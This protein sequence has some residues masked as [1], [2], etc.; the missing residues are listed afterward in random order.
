MTRTQAWNKIRKLLG[1]KAAYRVGEKISGPEHR[2]KV[3]ARLKEIDAHRE[4]LNDEINRR[5]N[6]LPWYVEMVQ[7]KTD[8]YRERRKLEGWQYYYRFEA[9]LKLG[10]CNEIVAQGDTWEEVIHKIEGSK[11]L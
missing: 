11:K 3:L 8:L 1:P 6:E 5:L 9:I 7:Q 10:W 4:H 2:E